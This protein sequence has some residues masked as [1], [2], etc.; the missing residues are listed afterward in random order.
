MSLV[1][2]NACHRSAETTAD[3]SDFHGEMQA[4]DASGLPV[5]M[6][7]PDAPQ[8]PQAPVDPQVASASQAAQDPKDL[9]VLIDEQSRRLGALRVHDPLEDRSGISQLLT[10]LAALP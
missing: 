5:S 7:V 10:L 8:G 1:S 9:D 2:K 4:T 6:I 3:Y